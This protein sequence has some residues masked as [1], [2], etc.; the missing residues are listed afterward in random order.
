M[1]TIFPTYINLVVKVCILKK[2]TDL[3]W[4]QL[5][6]ELVMLG[7]E[8]K[9]EELKTDPESG[10]NEQEGDDIEGWVDE[11]KFMSEDEHTELETDIKLICLMFMKVSH[12]KHNRTLIRINKCHR[13]AS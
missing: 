2:K 11:L 10:N 12:F 1:Y 4:R 7:E 5:D 8:S 6:K 13:S 9:V 3:T